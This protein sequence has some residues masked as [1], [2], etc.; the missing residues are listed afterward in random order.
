MYILHSSLSL[1]V[2]SYGVFL[3][4]TIPF[5]CHSIYHK[6]GISQKKRPPNQLL[7]ASFTTNPASIKPKM[8]VMWAMVPLPL[9]SGSMGFLFFN[10]SSE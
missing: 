9:S 10:N 8:A 6:Y 7:E 4:T 1:T 3:Y 2:Q 5:V